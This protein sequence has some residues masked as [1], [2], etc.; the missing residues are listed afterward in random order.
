MICHV[1]N[2][3]FS[4][5]GDTECQSRQRRNAGGRQKLKYK[6][7][8][9]AF[10]IE[11]TYIEEINQSVMYI[12]Q[13]QIEDY[14][15]IGR[16]WNDFK[17]F[18]QKLS[19]QLDED[20]RLVA[21]VHN[22]SYEFQFLAGVFHFDPNQVFA[23]D[24]RR[25]C[26]ADLENVLEL[27]CSYIQTNMSL[28]AFTH[29]MGVT[30]AKTHGFDY[31]K[32]RWYYTDLTPDELLYCI[33]DVR[34]LVQAMK[35]QMERDGDDLYTIPLTNTGYVRRDVKKAM[36]SYGYNRIQK[37][38]PDYETYKLLRQA[39]R[40]GNTHANRYFADVML[41]GV[42]SADRSSSYPEVE[43]NHAYPGTPFKFVD[44][45]TINDLVHWK[46]DLGR[47]F[48]CQIKMF[49]VK[50]RNEE[51]G[52][53][54]LAKA[55]CRNID[56][57]AIYDNGRILEAEYLETTLTDID[58]EIVME[59]YAGDYEIITACHSRYC[60]LPE[61]LVKTICE[62]YIR[63]T[64]LKNNDEEDP[65]GY[66]YMKS[67]NKLNSVY[68]MT[69]QD[70]VI[71]S[72]LFENGEF[73]T[74]D[75]AD[76]KALLEKSYHRSFI[77]Y[78]WG[79]WCTAWARWELEQGLKLVHGTKDAYFIY[80]DTDSIKYLGE[81]DWTAYNAAKIAT[82]KKSG[83]FA[84]DKKGAT[85]YMGVFEQ[86]EEYCRFKT[87]GAK[88]YAYTH[89]DEN[90][91]ET[92][93]EITIAGVP[94]KQGAWELRAAGGIDAFNIPFLFHAGKLESV[95]NDDVN[96]IYKNED[97]VDIRITR[98]V[99]LRP[100]TYNLGVATD[101]MWVLEDAKVFRKSMKLLTY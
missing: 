96:M 99:A 1:E 9:C 61:P 65:T 28:D 8:V 21:Y 36:K 57:G 55:K 94:K 62:Y 7:L 85:H 76:E 33:N 24:S 97:G 13:F 40:G 74:D 18:I 16:T 67:K 38:L 101:Y 44:S 39:F 5:I 83:A 79:V 29:K 22:L 59:E 20:E 68:G 32:R 25:V 63:K 37:L 90:D 6:N 64:G 73:K 4:V 88:K 91:E 19:F 86:E 50:L 27:R 60:M 78:Q 14:T 56:R 81:V 100:T 30:A 15:I 2:F 17:F 41:Y 54:Y 69:A 71:E 45:V 12:W 92:P 34:G 58:L 95:Y 52:C 82:S 48:L 72:I 51:W 87:F 70:P 53:P 77:P 23:I 3:P 84:T 26:K 93:V 43:C 49:H 35:I 98:N 66:F 75:S 46:K 42:K 31:N 10:D 89:W 80:D 11:T 47:A